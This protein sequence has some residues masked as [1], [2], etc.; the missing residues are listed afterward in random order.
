MRQL[1]TLWDEGHRGGLPILFLFVDNFYA[2]GGQTGAETMAYE[3]LARIGAGLN[4]VA[5]HAQTVDGNDPLAVA[6]A[7]A[8]ARETLLAGDGP[9]LLDVL[10]YRQSGHSP[11]DASSYRTRAEIE[12]WRAVDPI[13]EF[14][15]ALEEAGVIE[16]ERSSRARAMGR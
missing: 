10:C 3:R 16:P 9:V 8:R 12:A 7:V 1:S 2:M 5:L 11:S 6:D 14:G 4:E 13:T 15:A